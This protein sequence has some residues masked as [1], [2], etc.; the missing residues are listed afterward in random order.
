MAT[1][2]QQATVIEA[3]RL[4]LND[5]RNQ[6]G[7]EQRR[8]VV[9]QRSRTVVLYTQVAELKGQLDRKGPD[10]KDGL[11]GRKDFDRRVLP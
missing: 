4:D 5:L 7:L 8:T 6:L 2:E 11:I 9:E 10:K 1:L 3:M